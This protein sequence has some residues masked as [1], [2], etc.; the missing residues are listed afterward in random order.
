MWG[1]FSRR[2]HPAISPARSGSRRTRRRRLRTSVQPSSS[3]RRWLRPTPSESTGSGFARPP[4]T[5]SMRSRA[6]RWSTVSAGSVVRRPIDTPINTY[7]ARA[8]GP[9]SPVKPDGPPGSAAGVLVNSGEV[10]P[11]RAVPCAGWPRPKSVDLPST[12]E[13]RRTA[14]GVVRARRRF[15]PWP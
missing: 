2:I 13:M 10:K 7:D 11:S 15:E 3:S 9:L 5:W 14:P 6:V 1:G 12:R 4:D 8:F